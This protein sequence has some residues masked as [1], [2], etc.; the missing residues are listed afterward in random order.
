MGLKPVAVTTGYSIDITCTG[1]GQVCDPA[2]STT[3]SP[4]DILRLQLTAA[5]TNCSSITLVFQED[6]FDNHVVTAGKH[7]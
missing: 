3:I 1:S 2:Y 5:S 4:A 6:G 7:A